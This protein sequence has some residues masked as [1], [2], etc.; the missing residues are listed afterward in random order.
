MVTKKR[1]SLGAERVENLIVLKE[2][3][4]LVE[5]FR[6]TDR[7]MNAV[8]DSRNDAFEGVKVLVEKDHV[9]APLSELFDD[10]QSENEIW[11]DSS[12]DEFEVVVEK[13]T[14]TVT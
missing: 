8:G 5:E 9:T 1:N 6:E 14:S 4:R 2:N 12:D 7:E 11:E 13:A 3:M 10:D